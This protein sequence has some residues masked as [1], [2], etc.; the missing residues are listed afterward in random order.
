MRRLCLPIF[1][2]TLLVCLTMT[3]YAWKVQRVK[4]ARGRTTAVLKGAVIR[5]T[6]IAT[7]LVLAAVNDCPHYLDLK[8]KCLSG[9]RPHGR[10]VRGGGAGRGCHRA[11]AGRS[12]GGIGRANGP[13]AAVHRGL[14]EASVDGLVTVDGSGTV[15][16]VNSRMCLMAGLSRA[17]IIGTPFADYFTDP[18]AARAGVGRT[19]QEGVVTDYALTLVSRS[20]D[21]IPVSVNASV[22]RDAAGQVGGVFASARDIRDQLRAAAQLSRLTE[23][24][25]R[26]QEISKTGGWDFDLATGRLTWTDEVYR[27]YG[28]DRIDEPPDVAA[29]IAAFDADSR[30]VAAA[31]LQR[32]VA[33]GEA[34]DLELGLLRRDGRR[35][36]VR[37]IGRPEFEDGRIVRVG[38]SIVDVTAR[39][40]AEEQLRYERDLYNAT[41]DAAGAVV[42]VLDAAGRLLRFNRQAELLTGYREAEVLGRDPYDFLIPADERAD[43]AADLAPVA[44]DQLVEHENQ[45]LHRDGGRR[46]IHWSNSG[47]FAR[48][49]HLTHLIA[50]G[51][52]VTEQ[53]RLERQLRARAEHAAIFAEFA[54]GL[55]T[56][57]PEP[58][59]VL[60][61]MTVQV[62][63]YVGDTCG[64]FVLGEDN[65]T[66]HNLA[67]HSRN[68]EAV[69]FARQ[70]L[71][72]RPYT[73]ET[74]PAGEVFRTGRSVVFRAADVSSLRERL[75]VEYRPL[76][77]RFGVA[78]AV[79]VP[80][81]AAGTTLGVI[82]TYRF[83]GPDYAQD[84]ID[85]LDE[86][87]VRASLAY[88]NARQDADR[89]RSQELLDALFQKLPDLIC[90]AG[91]DGYF[92]LLNPAWQHILGWTVE[93]LCARPYLEFVH[94]DDRSQT[95]AAHG[96]LTGRGE[97]VVSFENRYRCRDGS[98]RWLQWNS[99]PLVERGILVAN[100][101][102][103]TARKQA[104]EALAR[105]HR[106]LE[107]RSE[108]LE[109]SNRNLQQ[110]AHIAATVADVRSL[111]ST[112]N[113]IA[114]VVVEATDAGACAIVL[115][116]GQPPRAHVAG[117]S[118]LPDDYPQAYAA[119][120]RRGRRLP[121]L[122]AY[123]SGQPVLLTDTRACAALDGLA[124]QSWPR[125]ACFPLIAHGVPVGAI[126]MLH[127]RGAHLDDTRVRFLQ[128]VADQVAVAVNVARLSA[129]AGEALVVRE[130]QRL[131]RELHDS[132]SQSLFSMTLLARASS[133]RL[134]RPGRDG[135]G[136][137]QEMLTDLEN[138]S[139]SALAEMRALLYELRP[140][141]LS[142]RS[143]LVAL[144]A[145]AD[146][147]QDRLGLDRRNGRGELAAAGRRG[148]GRTVPDRFGG[149]GQPRPAR[150]R[151]PGADHADHPGRHVGAVPGRRRDRLRRHHAPARPP[152]A[153]DH[154]RTRRADRRASRHRQHARAGHPGP[155]ARPAAGGQTAGHPLLNPVSP[156]PRRSPNDVTATRDS[157]GRIPVRSARARSPPRW[158]SPTMRPACGRSG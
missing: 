15:S 1:L 158:R 116:D 120:F 63:E 107:R 3:A 35:I 7:S 19:F 131:A 122:Q 145:Q 80:L 4:F 62:A 123:E 17:G 32:L 114:G 104:E 38:G 46:L 72:V 119:A 118:G 82:V 142:G 65:T 67:W 76:F 125:L 92:R 149:A 66:L 71:T 151:D 16:D 52:D 44:S 84:E 34:Y 89:K 146:A 68:P 87:G 9:L 102:D 30:P 29:A 97:P 133:L 105:S 21:R 140:Q 98:Y 83:A 22:F 25:N 112:L 153:G 91:N 109:R 56:L 18:D 136:E 88:E 121:A 117:L 141:T 5:A 57:G 115:V 93:E 103:V 157:A 41:L 110:F 58:G 20:G 77:D 48:D 33:A 75:P 50:V 69:A 31:A 28:W 113:T 49:G 59:G 37:T 156:D 99:L 81:R 39:K 90:I 132:V 78:S 86:F 53:R 55:A 36:W 128:T 2:A 10:G 101:R 95:R 155:R 135:A 51:V 126:E 129:Q 127:A 100:A 138:L 154:G 108:E 24:L 13:G 148:R 152:R 144:Q 137:L 134:R 147:L 79:Y 43:V 85:F 23:L 124:D 42:V 106:E 96:K 94:P 61:R 40:W 143:L 111:K 45:W 73:S 27:I 70:L 150:L 139:T 130:R 47:L 6:R 12:Q 74:G 60:E 26:T 14:I 54:D 64:V 11:A 8:K